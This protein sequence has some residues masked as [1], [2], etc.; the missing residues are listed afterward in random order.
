MQLRGQSAL[1]LRGRSTINSNPDV[2]IIVDNFPY[3]GD[4]STINPNDV[5]SVTLLKDA[6]AA[7]I[8]GAFS[9][10]GVMVITTKKGQ[11]RQPVRLSLNANVNIADMPDPYYSPAISAGDYIGIERFLYEKG[12]Y[13]TTINNGFAA[14]SPVVRLL[15]AHRKEELNDTELQSQLEALGRLDNRSEANKWYN[16]KAVNQ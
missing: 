6:A 12:A 8:W 5:V 2:L 14:L 1:T 10:N 13:T 7:S 11:Y 4:L 9:G 16:Q 3:D 15:E